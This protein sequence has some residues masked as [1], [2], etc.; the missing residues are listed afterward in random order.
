MAGNQVTAVDLDPAMLDRA[1]AFAAREGVGEDLLGFVEADLLDLRLP[2]AGRFG[3]AFIG[4]NSLMILPSRD[5]Q[6]R[7]LRILADHLAPGGVAVVDVWLPDADDLAR[8]DGRV[9]L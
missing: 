9:V 7:A 2:D 3:L 4:L 5:A 1:R 6:R 8:F